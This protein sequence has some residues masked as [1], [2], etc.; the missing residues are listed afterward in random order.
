LQIVPTYR[1]GPGV[2]AAGAAATTTHQP[3]ICEQCQRIIGQVP[4]T[5]VRSGLN[6]VTVA[7]TWPDLEEAVKE[8]EAQ[9]PGVV[10]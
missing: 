9:C 5:T 10:K 1:T 7:V 3:V 6:A 4:A 8:H 2:R